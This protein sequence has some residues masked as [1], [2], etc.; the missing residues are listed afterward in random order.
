MPSNSNYHNYHTLQAIW[1][2]QPFTNYEHKCYFWKPGFC[3]R[4]WLENKNPHNFLV[5][6]KLNK[7]HYFE[8]NVSGY[9]IPLQQPF[10]NH[11]SKCY[12]KNWDFFRSNFLPSNLNYDIFLTLQAILTNAWFWKVVIKL[13][14]LASAT[15]CKLCV[16]MQF[17]EM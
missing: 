10:T 14:N 16:Q 15:F 4:I 8:N 12:F 1:L 2:H 7:L 9:I 11:V 13:Y 3:K 6:S 5:I 17:S